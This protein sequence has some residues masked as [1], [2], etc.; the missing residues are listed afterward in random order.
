MIRRSLAAGA[1]ALAVA[2]CGGGGGMPTPAPR[3]GGNPAVPTALLALDAGN[4]QSA[5]AGATLTGLGAS[6]LGTQ[7]QSASVSTRAPLPRTHVL[8]RFIRKQIDGLTRGLQDSPA[9]VTGAAVITTP[10]TVSG[11][12]S[13]DQGTLSATE[14]FSACSETA[15]SSVTGTITID[16]MALDPGVSFS[17]LAGL[18]LTFSQ[19]G[20]ADVNITGSNV[21]VLE[22]V[23]VAVN[24]VTLSGTELFV[25]TGPVTERLGNFTLTAT[26][27]TA[28]ETDSVTFNYASTEIGGSVSVATLTPCVT[29]AAMNFPNSGVLSLAGAGGSKVQVTVNGDESFAAS[30]VTIGVDADGDGTFETTIGK[31]WADL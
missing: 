19:A 10:C 27:D 8:T 25:A 29:A 15:G 14:T 22:T 9:V 17:G 12:V 7:F 28:S 21:S 20:F 31:N 2:S 23:N 4:A 18:N 6:S 26:I 5:A 16:D 24:T 30:Q 13:L 3:G 11:S 1:A